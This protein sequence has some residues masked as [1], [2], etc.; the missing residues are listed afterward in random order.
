[1]RIKYAEIKNSSEK[2]LSLKYVNTT[3]CHHHLKSF[4]IDYIQVDIVNH[5]YYLMMIYQKHINFNTV[6]RKFF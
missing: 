3:Y 4:N 5:G 1:M 6:I 2:F